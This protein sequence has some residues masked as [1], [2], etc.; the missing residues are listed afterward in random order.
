[1]LTDRV[2]WWNFLVA[3]IV[4]GL[5]CFVLGVIVGVIL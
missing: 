2:F 5:P 1:M 4:L 3:F